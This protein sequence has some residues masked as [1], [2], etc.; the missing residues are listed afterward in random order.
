[1]KNFKILKGLILILALTFTLIGCSNSS[2]SSQNVEGSLEE[3]MASVYN[4]VDK[5]LSALNITEVTPENLSYYLGV[6]DLD[7]SEAIASEPVIS[8]HAH[9]VVL[10]RVNDVSKIEEIKSQ[11]KA[12]V[13]PRKWICVG[14]EDKNVI[15]DSIGDLVI[16]IMD[17]D[18]S[19]ELHKNFKNLS[20]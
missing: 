20:K 13:N 12:N 9:S 8:V 11:I 18:Y 2:N 1:M 15:V 5:N 6:K 19:K 14:I 16:L 3:I 4:G 10:A 17:N 7:Y